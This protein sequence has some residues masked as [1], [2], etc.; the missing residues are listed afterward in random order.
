MDDDIVI[1]KNE[2]WDIL[3]RWENRADMTKYCGIRIA[4]EQASRQSTVLDNKSHLILSG[5]ILGETK[6]WDFIDLCSMTSE[7]SNR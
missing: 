6:A 7:N 1:K 2:L 5:T 3:S 4:A